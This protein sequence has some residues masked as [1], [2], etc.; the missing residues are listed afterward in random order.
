MIKKLTAIAALAAA[1]MLAPV[2]QHPASA[3][4]GLGT[5]PT[6]ATGVEPVRYGGGHIGG[7][8]IGGGLS[9]FGGVSPRFHG[10]HSGG[11][12]FHPNGYGFRGRHFYGGPGIAYAHYPYRRHFRGFYG[13]GYAPYV[14]SSGYYGNGCYWLKVRALETGNP[15][16]WERYEDCI[17]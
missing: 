13:Y 16:W 7:I 6:A 3:L 9:H 8:H 2:P 17:D 11:M 14:Y 1:M 12:N 10:F 15:Y 4:T 5:S